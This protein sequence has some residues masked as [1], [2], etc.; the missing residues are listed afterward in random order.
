MA[1]ALHYAERL[2]ANDLVVAIT[3]DTGRN[4][5]TKMYS[6][7]WMR[8]M[9]Y[10]ETAGKTQCAGDVLD[11]RGARPIFSIGPDQPA[12]DAVQTFRRE[13]ISQM[14]VI[15]NGKVVGQIKEI[16]LARLL[17]DRRDPRQVAVREIM[18]T[19]LPTVEEKVSL[20]EVYRI[21]LS[22]YSGV[23]VMRG[24]KLAGIITR[25]D[26]VEF[27]DKP[28]TEETRSEVQTL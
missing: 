12:E 16:T 26:L 5:L 3:P 14:P 10:L 15:E 1:A 22:G 17:H 7:E 19:P 4:Y 23:L 13:N 9:G 21:L 18:G 20:D 11:W 28:A 8:E 6:D 25:I 27:W 24:G 2:E